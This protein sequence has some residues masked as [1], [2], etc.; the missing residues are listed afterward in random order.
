MISKFPYD[1]TTH[2]NPWLMEINNQDAIIGPEGIPLTAKYIWGKKGEDRE[3]LVKFAFDYYR[4]RGFPFNRLSDIELKEEFEKLKNKDPNDVINENGEIKNS[5]SLG[6]D[7]YKSFIWEKYYKSK[8][9]SKRSKSVYEVFYDDDLF[10]KVL[11][12]RMGYCITKEG[13][14]ER[15]FCFT[16]TDK[17]I[18]QGIKSSGLGVNISLFKPIVAKYLYKK[19]A[20]KRVFDYSSGWGARSLAAISLNLEYY[21]VDP[22][23]SFE[24]NEII[25][26]F[27]GKGKV[28]DGVSEDNYKD[29]PMVD[30]IMSCPPYFDQEIYSNDENQS[31][32]KY[33]NYEDWINIYWKNTVKNCLNILDKEGYFILI[34]KNKVGKY[35]I[36]EDMK[37]VCLDN[38]L[39]I[40]E[41]INYRTSNSHLSNKKN[42][43]KI[44]KNTEIVL[45][46]KN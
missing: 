6:N 32:I 5:S 3:N 1:E 38:N 30:C 14:E 24:N 20:K 41:E 31:V 4:K 45:V 10:L 26:F 21:G 19:Y 2:N 11:K 29:I 15:P 42:T 43:G 13:G 25:S 23:T 36:Y 8:G 16:I 33:K 35:N 28:I 17:M 39:I 44:S 22:L 37:K 9:N 12:N 46:F 27:N 18:I 40:V 7:I 34:M